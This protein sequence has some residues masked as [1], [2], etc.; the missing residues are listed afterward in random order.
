MRCNRGG[1]LAVFHYMKPDF[2]F[3]R[4]DGRLP[5][6]SCSS[7]ELRVKGEEGLVLTKEKEET[8]STSIT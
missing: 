4:R 8:G 5:C 2:R 6:S 3:C 7:L 1:G